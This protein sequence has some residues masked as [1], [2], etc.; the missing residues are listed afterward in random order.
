MKKQLNNSM[1]KSKKAIVAKKKRGGPRTGAGR[2]PAEELKKPVTIYVKES[3][4]KRQGGEIV[5]KEMLTRIAESDSI[6]GV[7]VGGDD[8]NVPLIEKEDFSLPFEK[9]MT[10]AQKDREK[11]KILKAAS[12]PLTEELKNTFA[13]ETDKILDQ[14]AA[15][16]AEKIPKE[17]D[18]AFGRKVWEND[19]RKRIEELQQK[20]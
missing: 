4:I 19:Q 2:K 17:R 3:C 1:G 11:K 8:L 18:T 16:R 10:S 15:I 12:P 14:I 9:P 6:D 13:P 20:L 5:L 7:S